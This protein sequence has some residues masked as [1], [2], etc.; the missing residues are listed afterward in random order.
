MIIDIT[1]FLHSLLIHYFMS[2]PT[3]TEETTIQQQAPMISWAQSRPYWEK[4]IWKK[5]LQ[6][7]II[8]EDELEIAYKYL[9]MD[10]GLLPNEDLEEI[11]FSGLIPPDDEALPKVNLKG[12]QDI[13]NVNAIP[14]GQSIAFANQL[15]LGWGM[16]GSG[17]SGYG[18][19]MANACYSRGERIIYPNLRAKNVSTDPASANFV[20]E[21]EDGSTSAI[22]FTD[23]ETDDVTLKR[24]AVFDSKCVNIQLNNTNTIQF[25]PGQLSVFDM[26]NTNIQVIEEKLNT[27]LATRKKINPIQESFGETVS[28]ISEYLLNINITATDEDITAV[29]TFPEDGDEQIKLLNEKQVALIKLDVPKKKKDLAEEQQTLTNYKQEWNKLIENFGKDRI[30]T[31]NNLIKD[32]I[33]KKAL[34][35][36]LGVQTFDDGIFKSVGT[37]KWKALLITAKEL[38]DAEKV[39]NEEKEIEHCLLCHQQLTDKEK[40]LFENYWL[41]LNDTAATELEAASNELNEWKEYIQQVRLVLPKTDNEQ[42]AIKLILSSAPEFVS[43]LQTNVVKIG[44]ILL[45]WETQIE[46]LKSIN[47]L[48]IPEINL[49]IID[50]LIA[51]KIKEADALKDPSEEIEKIKKQIL[52]LEHR[53]ISN[54]LQTNIKDYVEWLRWFDKANKVRFPKGTYTGQRTI[55]FN[56]IVTEEYTRIFNEESKKLNS[57]F[58]LTIESSGSS[59]ETY[60]KLKFDFSA[61]T[62]P[63]DVLSE[64]EQKVCALADFLSEIRLNK[65]NSGIIFDDPVTSLDHKGKERIA[66]RLVEESKHRQVIILTHDITFLLSLQYYTQQ[67]EVNFVTT[68]IRRVGNSTGIAEA[69]LPWIAQP[70]SKRKG[71]LRTKLQ[72]INALIN[73]N[74]PEAEVEEKVKIWYE[75]LRE[76]WERAV[77]ERLLKG[78]VERFRPSIETNRLRRL[79][80]TE[81]QRNEVIN[82][83]TESSKW[84][85]DRGAGLNVAIPDKDEM[86]A[87]LTRFES[88]ISVCEA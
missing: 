43:Q 45:A 7:N 14:D 88:F 71:I 68:T 17:K 12:I 48:S 40:T 18:R 74:S 2:N 10:L 22:T 69:E 72:D 47:N 76:A 9:K 81:E 29:C 86:A 56:Q 5:C 44:E 19:I 38:Y 13:T 20:I 4:Y 52:E 51:S 79:T 37:D 54:R 84:L 6:N 50:N 42:P 61:R 15:T 25:V 73:A 33:N 75:L 39:V 16:N 77:E 66:K 70:V 35:R 59:G 34:V 21:N 67:F 55:F 53:K 41:F 31:I 32:V 30:D 46:E 36:K 62:K 23:G 57:E 1:P 26:V 28:P 63:T 11:D 82:A 8:T 58:G 78:T 65:N 87:H 64:G 85:H 3:D 83:M 60:V 49:T 24:F 80:V 27:E